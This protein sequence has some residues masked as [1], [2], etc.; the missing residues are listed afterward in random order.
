MRIKRITRVGLATFLFTA[1]AL[2]SAVAKTVPADNPAFQYVGRIDF[3]DPKAPLL[4]WPGSQVKTTFTGSSVSVILDD[5]SG[6]NYYN[7]ILDGNSDAP[8]VINAL[9]GKHVYWISSALADTSHTIEIYKRTEGEEGATRFLGLDIPDSATVKAPPAAP[10]RK[11]EIYGDSITSGMGNEGIFNGRDDLPSQKNHYLSYGAIAARELNAQLHTISQS[12][13]GVLVSWFGF[14]MSDFY[15]QLI[16]VG[17]NDTQW[18]FDSWTPDVVVV[19]LFQNDRALFLDKQRL[20][21]TPSD[22]DFINA[23]ADFIKTL[24]GQY[25]E[26]KILCA[27]GSMDASAQE[28]KWPEIIRQAVAK[29][30]QAGD[31]DI[32]TLIFPFTG[33]TQHPRVMHHQQNAALLAA[34]IREMT[35]WQ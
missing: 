34:K 33:Y 7:I 21:P 25:P 12:G 22:K 8:Y 18:N 6:N 26:A 15:D 31:K 24:R 4:S 23:Y 27:L 1:I 16:A 3:T 11:I 14:T 2:S 13:I 35:G 19:N 32:D 10:K 20:N 5:D 9:Q 17:N 29:Q 28:S 30:Q